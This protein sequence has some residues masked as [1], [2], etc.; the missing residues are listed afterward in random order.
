MFSGIIDINFSAIKG[1][2][3]FFIPEYFFVELI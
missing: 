2:N 1:S 3:D